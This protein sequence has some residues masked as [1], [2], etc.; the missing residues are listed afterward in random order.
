MPSPDTAPSPLALWNARVQDLLARGYSSLNAYETVNKEYPG[1]WLE[2]T[3]E[4]ARLYPAHQT[5]SHA[6]IVHVRRRRS[7]G[8]T[9]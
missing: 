1:L 6:A 7:K 3:A 5:H 9:P 4:A 8:N 2:A